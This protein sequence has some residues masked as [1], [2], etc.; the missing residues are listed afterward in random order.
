M[1]K[2]VAGLGAAV[3]ALLLFSSSAG[4]NVIPDNPRPGDQVTTRMWCFTGS[5]SFTITGNGVEVPVGSATAGSD[6]KAELT[7]TLPTLAPGSYTM[8]GKGTSCGG[9]PNDKVNVGFTVRALDG[10]GGDPVYPPKLYSLTTDAGTVAGGGSLTATASGFT[11]TVSFL[12]VETGQD[13]GTAPAGSDYTAR[14]TF[15]APATAGS[16]TVR[17]TG[18]VGT[19]PSVSAS[20]VFSVVVSNATPVTPAAPAV[21]SPAAPATEPAVQVGGIVE[22]RN[23]T[24]TGPANGA[25]AR[26]GS[27]ADH[28]ARLAMVAIAAGAALL[29][30]SRR[31]LVRR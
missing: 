18:S 15:T 23:A 3:L 24:V 28:T 11:G 10:G 26:T 14:K 27:D 12:L 13:L 19:G 29:L 31:R 8:V 9:V 5:V 7:F 25:L 21:A 4:A 16:Y 30:A 1:R 2:A 17:A 6:G 22:S 20:T